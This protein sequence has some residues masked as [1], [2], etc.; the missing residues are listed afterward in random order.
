MKVAATICNK[1]GTQRNVYN[2]MEAFVATEK[3]PTLIW[4]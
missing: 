4:A 1:K 3:K 2:L